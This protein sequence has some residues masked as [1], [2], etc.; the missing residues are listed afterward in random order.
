MSTYFRLLRFLKPHLGVFGIAI[1]CM[2][3]SSL[4]NGVQLGALIPLADRILT[5]Q[6]IPAPDWLPGWMVGLV[7]WLNG[8][9]PLTILTWF[10]VLIPVLFF[11]K[12]LFEFWQTFYINEATQRV[13][14]DL[15]QTM[16]D[17]LTSLSLD[18]HQKQT[19][20]T[21]MS[22]ILYDT[23]VVQNTITEGVY[24]LI[25][26]SFQIGIF[27]T[28]ALS[29]NWHFA[30]IIF[31]LVPL[32]AWPMVQIGKILKKLSQ[33]AQVA[34]GQL[35]STIL[36]SI[37][38]IHVIQ[39]FLSEAAARTKF[40]DANE[41]FY[42]INRKLQKR[43]NFLSPMTEAIG[44][45]GGA[46]IFWY[47]GR[48]VLQQQMTLG[49]FL[50]FLGAILSLIR[51]FKRLSRL[52]STVQ[53]ALAAADRIFEVLD[54]QPGVIEHARARLL[55]P[56][57]R[58]ILFENVSFHYDTQPVLR[59][60]SLTISHGETVAF[61]G[62]SGGGKTTLLN[63]LPRFYDP[64]GGRVKIDAIDIKHVTLASLRSQ[65]GLVTQETMLFNDTVRAN[66]AL[67]HP[68]ATLDEIIAAAKSASAHRFI[69]RLPKGYDTVI[70]ERGDLLSGGERQRLAIARALVKNPA[71]LILDEATSQLDAESEHLIAE[72]I[73]QLCRSRTV[74]L[75]AH[76]LSTVRIAH[77]IVLI[78]EGRIVEQGR[79]DELLQKSPLYRRFCE[80][81]LIDAGSSQVRE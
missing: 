21:T 30:L 43:M 9:R 66:I 11:L 16:F 19:T 35:N 39:A 48:A 65:I 10:A 49:T 70:G 36:E 58:E 29:I 68:T 54:A 44:A 40:A 78:Q 74:L 73:E 18:Y 76:R 77:R 46:V 53:Q 60:V 52:H 55:P 12:G 34:M 64:H 17:R 2:G 62:P 80:L 24:D 31:V 75:I 67:G 3:V 63:L 27:L 7:G 32:I 22:R 1:G 8:I 5:N 28:I 69:S 37:S 50:V 14:R 71:I 20:G 33:Q 6:T 81:Q 13:M 26:Q 15:R 41:R 45:V 42:R 51:P 57:H 79:H 47:G 38:G 61:V 23:S 72:A 25:Y 56:F 4:L 59:G